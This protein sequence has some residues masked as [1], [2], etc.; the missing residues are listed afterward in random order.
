MVRGDCPT[1]IS[2]NRQC[3]MELV[4]HCSPAP[5]HTSPT[6]LSLSRF[7]L[8][9][10][11]LLPLF[12][13]RCRHA[14]THFSH[15]PN[16]KLGDEKLLSSKPSLLPCNQVSPAR[17]AADSKARPGRPWLSCRNHAFLPYST[18]AQETTACSLN[19]SRI[20]H[21]PFP[22]HSVQ[23]GCTSFRPLSPFSSEPPPKKDF[24]CVGFK[25]GLWD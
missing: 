8:A 17:T 9:S 3:W 2:G 6:N 11:F 16:K 10:L 22:I 25:R 19:P 23:R 15:C 1:G 12:I 4:C 13:H 24:S 14:V 5:P 18:L 21:Q 20:S 7:S